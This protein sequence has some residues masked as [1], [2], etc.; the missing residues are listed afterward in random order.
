MDNNLIHQMYNDENA[1]IKFN[2]II[3]YSQFINK[4]RFNNMNNEIGE[5]AFYNREDLRLI[6][7]E[8][9][10]TPNELGLN[11]YGKNILRIGSCNRQVALKIFGAIS[12]DKEINIFENIERNNLVKKQWEDK[13]EYCNLLIKLPEPEIKDVFGLKIKS[14]EKYLVKDVIREKEYVLMIKPINDTSYMIKETIFANNEIM[15]VHVPEILINIFY[16]KKPVKL[17]YVGKNNTELYVEHNIGIKDGYI[18]DGGKEYPQY[19]ITDLVN[20]SIELQNL[21]ADKKIP[22]ND[23]F[24]NKQLQVNE[25]SEMIRNKIINNKCGNSIMNGMENYTSFQCSDCKYKNMCQELGD[26][27]H[28]FNY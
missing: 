19:N 21:I 26:G 15:N 11:L 10:L 25:I 9:Y 16:F 8:Q 18:I 14:Y 20:S 6:T 28:E 13:L 12:E 27:I 2:N 3:D 7:E 1:N 22:N 5:K 4:I 24:I 17:L 23:Y